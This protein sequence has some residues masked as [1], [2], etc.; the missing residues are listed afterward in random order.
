MILGEKLEIQSNQTKGTL[1]KQNKKTR[2]SNEIRRTWWSLRHDKVVANDD[3]DQ[4]KLF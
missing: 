4:K 3:N 1:R 2:H